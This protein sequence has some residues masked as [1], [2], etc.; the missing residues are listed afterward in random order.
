MMGLGN[1]KTSKLLCSE[2]PWC[3]RRC[4][5]KMYSF[6]HK[7]I[8]LEI[9]ETFSRR[10]CANLFTGN[11]NYQRRPE[12]DKLSS[13]N[14]GTQI[15]LLLSVVNLRTTSRA[16]SGIYKL[17]FLCKR[18]FRRFHLKNISSKALRFTAKQLTARQSISSL[19]EQF[20]NIP[21]TLVLFIFVFFGFTAIHPP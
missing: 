8:I 11:R 19:A 21:A 16:S 18:S 5:A 2:V 4:S 6:D 7:F 17:M 1:E 15:R 20:S 14:L 12:E 3:W 9:R 10:I 13:F